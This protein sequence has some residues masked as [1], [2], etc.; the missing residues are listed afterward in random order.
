M[1]SCLIVSALADEFAEE[2]ER[3]SGGGIESCACRDADSARSEYR[4]HEVLFGSPAMIAEVLDEMPGVKWVQSSWAGVTPL[5]DAERRDYV[6]T[7]VKGVFGPQM[8]EYTLGY[9][10]AEELKI[11]ERHRAQGE[12]RWWRENSG[13]LAGKRLGIL[14]TGS[15]GAAIARAARAFDLEV[16][17]LSRSGESREHFRT[18]YPVDRLAEF[19]GSLDYLVSTLPDT[20]ATRSLLD[21]GNLARLPRGAVFVNVGRSNVVDDSALVDALCE[22][23]LAAAVL[24]VFDEEPLPADSPLWSAPNLRV[25]AHIAAVSHPALIV[26]IFVDNVRRYESGKPLE[27]VI[28]FDRGY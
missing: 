19:L 7:G 3:L 17:G 22:G 2:V 20:G 14:G 25:T 12:R 8:A 9:L 1:P 6:L 27:Y 10:L 23:R 4:G 24:D 28:D 26:P 15:I 5:I 21:A 11:L 18:M 16:V 13:T